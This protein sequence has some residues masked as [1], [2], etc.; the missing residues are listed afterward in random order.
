MNIFT[1]HLKKSKCLYTDLCGKGRPSH[2]TLS[3]LN[4]FRLHYIAWK[5][6]ISIWCCM[7]GKLLF[8]ALCEIVF[9][10]NELD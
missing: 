3:N 2:N 9:S 10:D 7:K 1:L 6:N 8:S 5:E 4:V